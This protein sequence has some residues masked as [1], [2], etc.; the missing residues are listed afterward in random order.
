MCYENFERKMLIREDDRSCY[1]GNENFE[2]KNM[3][4][5]NI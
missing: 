2:Y 5:Y 4:I 1:R 3:I